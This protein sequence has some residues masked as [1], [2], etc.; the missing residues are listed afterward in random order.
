MRNL[1]FSSI[2]FLAILLMLN[3][4]SDQYFFRI[5]LTEDKQYTLSKATKDILS[6]LESPV[7]VKAYFSENLPSNVSQA[8]NDVLDYLIEYSRISN[9]NLVYKFIDPSSNESNEAEAIQNGISP[10]MINIREKDQV[11]QQKAYLGLVIEMLDQKETIPFVKPGAALEYA[12]SSSI[13]KV[14]LKDKPVIGIVQANGEAEIEEIQ[15]VDAGLSVLYDV[16][17]LNLLNDLNNKLYSTIALINPEDSLTSDD[18]KQLDNYLDKGGNILIA[19]N[20]VV[21]DFTN[22]KGY[23]KNIGISNWL[24]SKGITVGENFVIDS[25]CS[26]ISVQQ[27]QGLFRYQSSISFP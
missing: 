2:L 19:M 1:S 24:K 21:G 22:A 13:K 12:L 26:K 7:T 8:K 27:Q 16:Q 9:N 23:V 11:K 20:A 18:L 10:V 5:D 14:S 4:I 15:Q 25:N 17:S 6:N 3:L